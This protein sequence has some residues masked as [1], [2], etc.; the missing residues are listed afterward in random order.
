M[1]DINQ[2][3]LLPITGIILAG[4]KSSRMGR[5]KAFMSWE[6]EPLIERSLSVFKAVFQEVIISTNQ[7]EL[8]QK[9]EV[10][11]VRDNYLD[12]GPLGG[13]EASLRASA[14]NYA[15]FAACDMPFLSENLIRFMASKLD[16]EDIL[17]PEINGELHPLHAFYH[18]NCLP[19]FERHLNDNQLKLTKIIRQHKNV[20]YLSETELS[21]IALL[22]LCFSNVNTPE[23]WQNL[24]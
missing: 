4:G 10:K 9:Y 3:S 6:G 22:E 23:E 5:N 11:I 17:V 18:K 7:P 24:N 14:N 2:A 13:L 20:H 8:Y 21:D 1:D 16:Q 15:F 12:H 19:I